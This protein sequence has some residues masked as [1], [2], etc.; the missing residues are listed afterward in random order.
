MTETAKEVDSKISAAME[1]AVGREMG[2]RMSFP[3]SESDIRRWAI[4]VYWPA[5]PPA[6]F[7]DPDFAASTVHAGIVAPEEFNPFA[8]AVA[9]QSS[10]ATEPIEANDPDK[11]ERTVGIQGP[12]LSF[13]MNGGLSTTYGARIR[14]GDV[15]TSV[16]RLGG[17]TERAGSLG[18]MLLSTIEDEWTN[19]NGELVKR[20]VFTLIRY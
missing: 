17:Y 2:R 4:A 19:Q 1:A 8:W 12:G 14:P 11:T 3:V 7:T 20:T 5:E 6:L 16:S 13:Q 9:A 10:A 15:I 18:K